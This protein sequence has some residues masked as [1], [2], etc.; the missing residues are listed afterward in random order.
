M[1]I[2]GTV[3]HQK[4]SGGFWG[5]VGTG[6]NNWRPVKMPKE[7][8]VEDLQVELEAEKE[9]A[10]GISIFMWGTPIRILEFKKV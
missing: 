5:I 1:K 6:G 9:E 3:K 2:K 7:L 8:Q 10:S 4:L